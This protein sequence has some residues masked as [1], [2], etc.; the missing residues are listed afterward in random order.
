MKTRNVFVVCFCSVTHIRNPPERF[1]KSA[2]LNLVLKHKSD[3]SYQSAHAVSSF[4]CI[5]L[6]VVHLHVSRTFA[7]PGNENTL[8]RKDEL[9]FQIMTNLQLSENNCSFGLLT[10]IS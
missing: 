7:P 8:T 10:V 4:H 1:I 2:H 6:H 9:S 5:Q 3:C